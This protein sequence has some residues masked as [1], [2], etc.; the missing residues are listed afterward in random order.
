MRVRYG[1]DRVR[2]WLL[3]RV[4]TEVWRSSDR[5]YA[6]HDNDMDLVRSVVV[7]TDAWSDLGSEQ[8]A[9]WLELHRLDHG[10]EIDLDG[11]SWYVAT[12]RHDD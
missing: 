7:P 5:F 3:Q 8:W 6:G 11:Q 4:G 9:L 2:Y 10:T 1:L 12:R